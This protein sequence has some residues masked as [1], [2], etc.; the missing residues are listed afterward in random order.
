[1]ADR[2]PVHQRRAG[3]RSRARSNGGLLVGAA[4]TQRPELFRAVLCEFPDLDMVGYHRFA[5]NNPPALLEYGDASK[6]EQ[7]P[8]L[9]AYSPYQRVQAGRR[10][11]RPC[12]SRPATPT[13]ACRRSRPER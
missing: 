12:C 11:T 6:P 9:Y 2:E 5:N 4:L 10:R 3:W 8:F 13:R 1:M 7:F